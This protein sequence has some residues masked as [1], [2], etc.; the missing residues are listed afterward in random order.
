MRIYDNW[1]QH[2]NQIFFCQRCTANNMGSISNP[3]DPGFLDGIFIADRQYRRIVYPT[4]RHSSELFQ[5]AIDIQQRRKF[6]TLAEKLELRTVS[7]VEWI[8]Q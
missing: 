6:T 5:L 4:Y 3:S 8:L 7:I 1:N 2:W